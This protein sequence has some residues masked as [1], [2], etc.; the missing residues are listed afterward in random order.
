MGKSAQRLKPEAPSETRP[1]VVMEEAHQCNICK[2]TQFGPG[3]NNR[4]SRSK[5]PPICLKCKSLERHRAGRAVVEQLRRDVRD[6]LKKYSLLQ[7][8]SEPIVANG[9]F[10][11][12]T[13][14][15]QKG[16]L[17][18]EDTTANFDFIVCSYTL[19][20][21]QDPKAKILEMYRALSP[22]GLIFLGYPSPMTRTTTLDWGAPDPKRHGAYRVFGRDFEKEFKT[23]IPKAV[24]MRVHGKDP[25]TGDEEFSYLITKNSFWVR[26]VFRAGL[27]AE[28][29]NV[30]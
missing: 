1:E 17:K 30:G 25:V 4:L 5:I 28:M 2:G 3:P 27:E 21:E 20:S 13:Q 19:Q 16:T 10:G 7:F 9:W 26:Q 29:L 14:A 24:V 15:P 22:E 12:V 11:S 18:R 8:S 23:I 6:K